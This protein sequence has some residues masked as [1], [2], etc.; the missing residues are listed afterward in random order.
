MVSPGWVPSSTAR[1][2]LIGRR[3]ELELLDQVLQEASSGRPRL[4]CVEGSAGVGKS[5]LLT[6]FCERLPGIEQL[7]ASGE[8]LEG[9]LQFGVIDQLRR[10]LHARGGDD[11]PLLRVNVV[12]EPD[13]FMV[14][15]NL[16]EAIGELEDSGPV[17]LTI[18]DAHWADSA[19]LQ[20]IA[21][22]FRRLRADRVMLVLSLRDER[23]ADI[24]EA[25]RRLILG[26]TGSRIKLGGLGVAEVGLLAEQRGWRMSSE[27]VER[28][29]AHTGGNPLYVKAVLDE[30][31]PG[32]LDR[33]EGP[34]P[35]PRS[36][37]E[38]IQT[39]LQRCSPAANDL[40]EAACILG[41]H[42]SLELVS[43]LVTPTNLLLTLDEA[44]AA[45][46][47][48]HKTDPP[49]VE[50]KFRHPLV[51]AAV[52]QQIP[53]N[54]RAM[55]HQRAARVV[56]DEL[57]AL[58]HELAARSGPDP[59]LAARFEAYGR[60]QMA[61]GS[62]GP[63]ASAFRSAAQ[64]T[65]R[66]G[67]KQR[68]TLD[69][70]DCELLAGR[71]S[72]TS[73]LAD[74]EA[75]AQR[76]YVMARIEQVSGRPLEAERLFKTAWN[77]RGSESE[78][79]D[80]LSWKIA[81]GFA[82]VLLNAGR[83][84]EAAQWSNSA[85][86][87]MRPEDRGSS[88]A[89]ACLLMS[90]ASQGNTAEALSLV[91]A[92]PRDP[93]RVSADALEQLAGRGVTHLWS[94][95]AADARADLTRAV[96]L[97]RQRGAADLIVIA[98]AYLSDAEYR[99]GEWDAAIVHGELAVSTAHDLHWINRIGF[100]HAVA[101][102]P[103]IGR[104]SW[105]QAE[106]H[107]D[108]AQRIALALGSLA[109]VGYTAVAKA[110]LALMRQQWDDAVAAL[111][112]L[113]AVELEPASEPG[114]MAWQLMYVEGLLHQNRVD[115]AS[116]W[117]ELTEARIRERGITSQLSTIAWLRADLEARRG[118]LPR[119]LAVFERSAA[120]ELQNAGLVEVA[121]FELEYGSLLR[122]SGRRRAAKGQLEAAQEK[123][124]T[125]RAQPLLARCEAELAGAGLRPVHR[126]EDPR[127]LL[128]SQELAVA[129]L[130]ADGLTN[131]QVASHLFISP[132]TVDYHLV[133]VYGKLGVNSR[134]QLVRH[135]SNAVPTT[136]RSR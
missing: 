4:V 115:A 34:L 27:M 1:D 33:L 103:Y 7:H 102:S 105:E 117:L 29:H 68:R 134:S 22:A 2:Q 3:S 52:Y 67:E 55:L 131:R 119:A 124:Q 59:D 51:A 86:E 118:N 87:A 97:A 126:T 14:G 135:F 61:R 122:R 56:Q 35:V 72:S 48:E 43:G 108:Q 95:R 88:F 31:E 63:A 17:L 15:L 70:I 132:R 84:A 92:L 121:R 93:S 113:T 83:A 45:G 64:L 96:E 9:V 12:Q 13:P 25:L 106:Q 21:F 54:R 24:P 112:P 133:H 65:V 23:F 129:R 110:R 60:R 20:A 98:L 46:F 107:I 123:L 109:S 5:S 99:L 30:V 49:R 76:S 28:L 32:A 91:A 79:D 62:Y 8:Q 120:S 50:I 40:V 90:L 125:L 82:A 116:A 89:M 26:E 11:G 58:R 10:H 6:A 57:V 101:A 73:D 111:E 74:Y 41:C 42:S 38:I 80:D 94:D 75:T 36:Y 19:S 16:L 44:V 127:N 53:L 77:A 85:L 71:V 18:D 66:Q 39:R 136:A 47:F 37:A 78:G 69:A 130:V 81:S 100:A 104:G 128:T 114:V